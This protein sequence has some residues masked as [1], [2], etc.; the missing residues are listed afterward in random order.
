MP[1][2]DTAVVSAAARSVAEVK[3]ATQYF[4]GLGR[5][6]QTVAKGISATGKD[7]VTPVVY[8]AFGR[9]QYKYLPYAQQDASDGK[10]KTNPFNSQ[11]SFYQNAALNPGANGESIY[12]SQTEFE[13][14]PL[15]RVLNN[16]S[17]G[18]SWAKE[19]GNRAVQN[20][21]LVNTVADS[22][23]LWSI[24]AVIPV[25]TTTYAA[26]T[27]YKNIIIDEAGNQSVEYKD[28]EGHV[29]LKKV[30]LSATPGTAHVGWLCTYYVY[31]DLGNLRFVIAPRAVELISANWS[32]SADM[33]AELCFAYRYDGRN[34]MI[35]KKVP[36][37]D[38]TEMVYDV[39]DRLVFSRTGNLRDQGNWLVTFYDNLNRPTM[40]ALYRSSSS[41][42]ALQ[43]SMNTAVSNTTAIAYTFPGTADLVLGNYDGSSLYQA[44]N[45]ITV[46]DGFDS[47]TGAEF[48]AEINA[49]ANNGTTSVTVTNPLPGIASS[50]L[51]P[52]TYT[53]YDN[54]NYNGKLDYVSGDITKP[55]AG[56]NPYAE[57]LPASAS[58]AIMGLT[59]G[60]KVRVLETNQW[61]T[62]STYYDDKGRAIQTVSNNN[63]GGKD[64][65]TTLYDFSGKILSTYLRQTNVRSGATP[66]TTLLTM[67]Q[68]DDGGRLVSIKKRLNDNVSL[69]RTIEENSY[70]ELGQLKSKRIG[71]SSASA[72]LETLNYEYNLRG[73]LKGINKSFV[74]TAGSTSNWFGQE[75]SYD[76]GFSSNQFNGNIS[77]IK[78]KSGSDGTPRA[79]GYSYDKVN[80]ITIADFNQQNT[81]GANWTRDKVDFS[82][83]GLNY[84]ANGNILSMTQK[85]MIGITPSTIDQLTYSYRSNSNKLMAV[86]D[87]INTSSAGLGDFINGT[88]AGNDYKY[89][90]SGN[91]IQDLNKG[92]ASISYN[93]LNLPDTI[94]ITGKGTITY[95][96]D[97]A[98]NKLRKT[99]L[100]NTSNPAKTT[101][102]DYLGGQVY[103]NDTLQLISHEDG[104][105]R[106]VFKTGQPLAYA[107]DYFVK[108]HLGNIR[109]VLGTQSDAN[110]YAA[111]METAAS[112]TENALFSNIDV[113]RAPKPVGYPV[114]GTTNPNDYVAKLN[115]TNGQKVGPSLVLR[116][117]AGDTIQ[118][119]V[120]AFYKSTAANTSSTTSS[121]M[122]GSL[123]SA[124]SGGSVAD[125]SHSATG[126]GSPMATTYSS[127]LY[128]QLKQ[129]DPSQ[130]L[131]DKPKAYLSYV[132]FD[133]RFNM[134]DENSGVKQVQGTP[135]ALQTL[136]TDRL[137]IK[138]T[139]F[140]YIY[141]SNESG[142]DV[143]FDNLVV[144]HNSGPLLEETH[145]YPFGLTMAGISSNALKGSN[146][147]ENR[148]KYNGKELQSKEFGDGSGL[149]LY[150][151]GA[152]MYDAQ[153]GRWHVQDPMA[154]K[155]IGYSPYGYANNSPILFVDPNGK[156]IWIYYGDNQKARYNNGRLYNEDGSKYK[157]KDQF[158]STVMKTLN[159]MN[160]T[161]I[162][163]EVLTT[164]S[165][166][167]NKFDFMNKTPTKGGKEIDA[168]QFQ[169][170]A[171]GGGKIWAGALMKNTPG[172]QKLENTAH[173]LFHGY[174][175]E[176]KQSGASVNNEVGAYLFGQAVAMN[177]ALNG[178]AMGGLQPPARM[179]NNAGVMYGQAY[180]YLLYDAKGVNYNTYINYFNAL[181]S[182]KK[183][184]TSNVTG[185]YN[186]NPML[187]P[188]QQGSVIFK[189]FPLIREK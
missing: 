187:L 132:L 5:P 121:A 166:S 115:A 28:K 76:Y 26:G 66:Q 33:A 136:A 25:S 71:V 116:V 176:N 94:I 184:S 41:R 138:K 106:P 58:A 24:N 17:A 164:L 98:G 15:N 9:E 54:Y 131:P 51:T 34:R 124:F 110:Q 12:Y 158:V 119:G 78:W 146:Y 160:S 29:V 167:E 36:G 95:L 92:I 174:Q 45:S 135:D 35:V 73:W 103:S 169:E 44:T 75:L 55:Q 165:G 188:N 109:M 81:N 117:M 93:H 62:T 53:F 148:L 74:N 155:Y 133:D 72:Q 178:S 99:V 89:D 134:V 22:V 104:R 64:V 108:D 19:G 145:Y 69:E 161:E 37:A 1:T 130:N 6:I 154:D 52:L 123:L 30:Q 43:T 8:D 120:K 175:H 179:D 189:F 127:A 86:A 186:N 129:K 142:A 122:L 153:I 82:V 151:Y 105:I 48:S 20:Q 4:D 111:T 88:N 77:G 2:T 143:F 168:L 90:T 128:D 152:R 79:Y 126:P 144:A 100:D 49:N 14:S 163:K 83:S 32:I 180:N 68:Y 107:F 40:T 118:L 114:D 125:G 57:A 42:D 183:G 185:L 13:S 80:R 63:T 149:E 84:D 170:N 173:E 67:N 31:D 16:Y 112:A 18:N 182:F 46:Q 23:R 113:T 147:S 21:Y 101:V 27:L 3:Q 38:S 11:A 7:L 181:M 61:L 85:G 162:G 171:S 91:L 102:T 172:A 97:A 47:G 156:E 177:A 59:T 159:Q 50:A 137:T 56:S 60:V 87:P 140:L 150:D 157:G 10:F 96:Y 70:D 139:G 65:L 39:R 141:T